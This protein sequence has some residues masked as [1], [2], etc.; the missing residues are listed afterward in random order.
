MVE[1]IQNS[2]IILSYSIPPTIKL[3][4]NEYLGKYI[5]VITN[6][7]LLFLKTTKNEDMAII[8]PFAEIR[9]IIGTIFGRKPLYKKIGIS[10]NDSIDDIL[11]KIK[12]RKFI[13]IDKGD[14]K[15]M[16][17]ILKPKQYKYDSNKL[18]CTIELSNN[19][20]IEMTSDDCGD[21]NDIYNPLSEFSLSIG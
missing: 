5:P 8:F 6:K 2:I 19:D 4:I 14:I 7:R 20:V 21:L 3:I 9:M 12:K 16:R 11:Q 15:I 13:E 17:V 10:E 1:I 18:D